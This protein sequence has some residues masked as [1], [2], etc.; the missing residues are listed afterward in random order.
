MYFYCYIALAVYTRSPAAY[1]ALSS[2][3]LLQLPSAGTLKIYSRRNVEAAGE[4]EERLADE[5]VKYDDRVKRHIAANKP[6]PP[7]CKG[8][9]IVDEVK[10]AAKL[11]WNSRNDKFVGH[12]MTVQEM[13]TLSDL[14]EN[15]ETDSKAEKT[16]YVMQTLWR[17]LSSECD[18][19]GPYY[20]TNGPFKAKY[21]LACVMDALRK[22]EAYG[23]NVCSFI[24]DG[25]SS[26][27]T[28]IKILLECRGPF[29]HND[30]LADR[31]NVPT[32]F[33]NPFTGSQIHIIICPSH[34]VCTI[35]GEINNSLY[36]FQLKNTIA[37][38]YE[39]RIVGGGTN[40]FKM[41]GVLFGWDSI[42]EML[43]REL[44]RK[45]NNQLSRVPGLKE[46]YVYRDPWTRLN[47]KP[48]KI[49]QVH[50][51]SSLFA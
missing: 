3:N 43:Q 1:E 16:N 28:M 31:H 24:C 5:R 40:K 38:L 7:L 47:V 36:F 21:M 45:K 20:T 9:I 27:L 37:A 46:N 41:D 10:V 11:H 19:V 34:Q 18:I 14:Y 51:I 6:S 42:E 8:A 2:F 39:S 35:I 44:E 12:S 48:A 4:V 22:F 49:M 26:N 15:L 13:A 23:F 29:Y 30:D 32:S 17:D 33:T 50:T 25:A